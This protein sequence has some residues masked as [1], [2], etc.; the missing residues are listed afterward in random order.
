MMSQEQNDLISR[1]GPT[2][3]TS[4]TFLIPVFAVAWAWSLLAEVPTQAM[5][6]GADIVDLRIDARHARLGRRRNRAGQAKPEGNNE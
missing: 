6:A 1:I 2:R 3:A 4:V 5:L